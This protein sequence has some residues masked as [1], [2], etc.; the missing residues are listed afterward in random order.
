[1]AASMVDAPASSAVAVTNGVDFKVGQVASALFIGGAGN[2]SI[3]LRD[4]NDVLFTGLIA[5]QVL[6]VRCVR[7]NSASTTATN[8]VALFN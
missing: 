3:R 8:I 7:V 6:P 1:M 4:G 5:G 2:A